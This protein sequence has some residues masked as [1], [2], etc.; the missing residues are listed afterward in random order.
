MVQKAEPNKTKVLLWVS[1]NAIDKPISKIV[2]LPPGKRGMQVPEYKEV[3]DHYFGELTRRGTDLNSIYF[4][5][6]GAS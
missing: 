1:C 5:Q 2:I 4:Q 6:D 3:L